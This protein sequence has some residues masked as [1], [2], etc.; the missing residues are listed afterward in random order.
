MFDGEDL[1]RIRRRRRSAR[2]AVGSKRGTRARSDV[3]SVARALAGSLTGFA[4][5]QLLYH[6]GTLRDITFLAVNEA[7]ERHTGLCDVRRRSVTELLP[8]IRL[9]ARTLDTLERVVTTGRSERFDAFFAPLKTWFAVSVSRAASDQILALFDDITESKRTEEQLRESESRLREVLE[10]A[11]D[12]SYK[13]DLQADTY[14]YVSP[15][16]TAITGYAPEELK[17]LPMA[18]I[19]DR[20]HPDDLQ[21]VRAARAAPRAD[22]GGVGVGQVD[23]RIRRRDER[24]VWLRDRFKVM[25]DSNGTPAAVI[26]S[27]ADIDEQK[28]FESALRESEA[29]LRAVL[30]A[31]DES[32][33]LWAA[34]GRLLTVNRVAAQRMGRG[35]AELVGRRAEELFPTRARELGGPQVARAFATGQRVTFEDERDGRW[36]ANTVQ[37][38]VDADGRVARIAVYSR[39]LT[40]GRK[41]DARLRAEQEALRESEQRYRALAA[42][43]ARLASEARSLADTKAA[44]L[45]DTN[46]RVKNGLGLILSIINMETRRSRSTQRDLRAVLLGLEGRIASLA[47]VHDMLASREKTPLQLVAVATTVIRSALAA[48]TPRLDVSF[49][50]TA[51]DDARAALLPARRATALALVLNELTVN[52]VKHAW[53]RGGQGRLRVVVST[54]RGPPPAW[55]IEFRDDGVGWPADVLNDGREG[56]GLRLVRLAAQSPLDATVVLKPVVA[57]AAVELTILNWDP[58]AGSCEPAR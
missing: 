6:D 37:P 46:H 32:M 15:V 58:A 41:A 30:D 22:A 12:A 36:M 48:G 34:D 44:L 57:G 27:V 50:L 13:R 10:N 53:P 16:I 1:T 35:A 18:A 54:R 11:L 51:D 31:S 7:F 38:I 25:H 42:E 52:S 49:E 47:V 45:E 4:W 8:G 56:V 24:Y 5:G 14:D 9:D 43:N 28:A 29:S 33:S 23:F 20:V 17:G 55:C 2:P 3:E 39:D 19:L 21:A 40:E 26:G